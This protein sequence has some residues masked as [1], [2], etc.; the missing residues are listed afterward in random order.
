M[1]ESS[2]FRHFHLPTGAGHAFGRTERRPKGGGNTSQFPDTDLEEQQR[3]GL[4][5]EMDSWVEI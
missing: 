2:E 1:S 3:T 4:G 5:L